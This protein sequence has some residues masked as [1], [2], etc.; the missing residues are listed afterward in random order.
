MKISSL[1]NKASLRSLCMLPLALLLP[2]GAASAQQT[3]RAAAAST[4]DVC[5]DSATGNWRYFGVVATD[6]IRPGHAISV[7]N[8]IQNKVSSAG[9]DDVYTQ[10]SV[11]G[12]GA[13]V[14]AFSIDAAPLV[15][16][17]LRHTARLR[18][19]DLANPGAAAPVLVAA[20]HFD[21]AVCGCGHPVGCTRTQ[22]YWGKKP[23]VVWPAPYSRDA[24]FH[25]S[26]LTWQQVGD[27]PP[28]HGN[29]YLILAHQFIAAVLNRAGGASAPSAVQNTLDQ[30]RAFFASGTTLQSCASDACGT[31]KTWAAILDTYNNGL[32]P[33]APAACPD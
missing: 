25:S 9:F 6:R 29:A 22:G 15:L 8:I 7:D 11:L 5:H 18:I 30:A 12:N 23:G 13:Q 2:V 24:M 14:Q 26:G 10:A 3:E 16:G 28:K 33:G 4:L 21:T 32:Y 1:L 27:T 31:Q 20:Y 17:T 19:V